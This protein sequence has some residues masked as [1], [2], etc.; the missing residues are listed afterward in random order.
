MRLALAQPHTVT[1]PDA[2]DNV[3]RAAQLAARAADQC[4]ALIAGP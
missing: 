4:A 1:G 2:E 3:A